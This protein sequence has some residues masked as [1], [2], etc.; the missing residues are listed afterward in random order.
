MAEQQRIAVVGAGLAGLAAG[1]HLQDF[2]ARVE[3]FERSRLLGGR[4]TSFSIDGREVDNGQH[5]FLACCTEFIDFVRRIGMERYLHL[6]PEFDALVLA[7][8]GTAGHLRASAKRPAPFHLL[9]SF[10]R[11]PHLSAGAKVRIARA[12][13]AALFAQ[14]KQRDWGNES[15]EGW[16]DRMGQNEPTRRAFW[17]P[18]FIP[19]LNAPFDRV[20]NAD[21]MFVLATAFLRDAGAARFGFSTVPLAHFAA[22]AAERLD[23]VHRATP[24]AAIDV[25]NGAPVLKLLDGERTEAFDGVVLAVPPRALAKLLG[26]PARFGLHGLDDFDAVPIV[27]V[28][29]W[30]DGPS[31]GVD[32][33]AALDSPLQWIFEKAPGYLCCSISAAEEFLRLPTAE[34]EALAW[35]EVGAFLPQLRDAKVTSSAVTRNPEAT[36]LPRSNAQRPGSATAVPGVAIAGAWTDTGGWPDTME[37]AIRSGI[38]AAR[39][40]R[41]RVLGAQPPIPPAPLL[42]G[43]TP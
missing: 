12:L 25:T 29:L 1:L 18:F 27:D 3:L 42:R 5:V 30:H 24:V 36:Y 21:A 32:F 14:R 15:F 40:L 10:L 11:Y 6:Q 34:L 17:D 26:D 41:Y 19:A 37:S 20:R 2:G 13:A 38:A 7:R 22:A 23:A 28:H 31:I 9:S 33:A 39:T 16:L 8:D 43:A 4:A 35:R